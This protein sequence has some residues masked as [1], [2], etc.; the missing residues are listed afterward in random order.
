VVCGPSFFGHSVKNVFQV[1]PGNAGRWS[2]ARTA[3]RGGQSLAQPIG[4]GNERGDC[5]GTATERPKPW[6]ARAIGIRLDF[7]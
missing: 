4:N 2:A 5:N 1:I 7:E 6:V 3:V